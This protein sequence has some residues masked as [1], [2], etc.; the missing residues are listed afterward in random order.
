MRTY[1]DSV[2][3]SFNSTWS[4]PKSWRQL[5]ARLDYGFDVDQISV[6]PNPSSDNVNISLFCE[7]LIDFSLTIVNSLGR[8]VI[9]ENHKNYIGNFTKKINF[10]V[11]TAGIYFLKIQ[12][13]NEFLVKKI[14]IK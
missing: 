14:I 1:C 6:Y 4:S 10:K 3:T 11:F 7:E 2:I 8:I 5:H 12:K 9:N 13:N